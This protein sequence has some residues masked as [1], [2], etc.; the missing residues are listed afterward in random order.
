MLWAHSVPVILAGTNQLA[1][2]IS[3]TCDAHD[4]ANHSL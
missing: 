4:G 2:M 3:N 1:N